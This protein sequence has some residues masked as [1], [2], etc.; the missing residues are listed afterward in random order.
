LTYSFR[1]HN[2]HVVDSAYNRNE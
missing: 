2:G 1:S